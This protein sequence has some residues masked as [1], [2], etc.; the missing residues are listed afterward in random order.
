[1]LIALFFVSV[2]TPVAAEII[3]NAELLGQTE[4]QQQRDDV[5]ESLARQDMR[6]ALLEYGVDTADVE[7]RLDN[8]SASELAQIQGQ[9]A[10]L[11]AGGNGAVG[12]IL[13]VILILVLLDLLG[14][15]NVFPRI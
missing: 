12:V 6:A 7:K 14:A 13:A 5:R 10:D 1:M 11:P 8:L 4:W 9:L 3:G 15:T 2:Q